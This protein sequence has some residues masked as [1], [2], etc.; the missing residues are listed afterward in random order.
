MGDDH[1]FG[2]RGFQDWSRSR[3]AR[4]NAIGGERPTWV[5]HDFRRLASTVMH[6]KLGLVPHIVEAEL[7]LVGHKGGVAGTYNRSE[8]SAEKRWALASSRPS[9]PSFWPT[10]FE[11]LTAIKA[12]RSIEELMVEGPRDL[13]HS[14]GFRANDMRLLPR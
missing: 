13:H 3:A 6:D 4:D 8:Y 9:G 14:H 7:V 1:V 10:V 5:L 11:F 12:A 2:Q